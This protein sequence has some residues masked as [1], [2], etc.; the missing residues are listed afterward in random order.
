MGPLNSWFNQLEWLRDRDGRVMCDCLRLEF[1]EE[2]LR[3]YLDRPIALTHRN[4][5]RQQYDY[6]AMYT[7][8]LAAIVA[9]IFKEDIDY[10]GFRFEGAA[11]RNTIACR[12]SG[13]A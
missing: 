1:L 11:T 12:Q 5:T 8:E 9:T 4:A 2:D 3:A 10:F 6:R 13:F 7:P